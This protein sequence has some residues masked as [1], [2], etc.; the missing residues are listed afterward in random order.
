M[1]IS[2]LLRRVKKKRKG[3][4]LSRLVILRNV[5]GIVFVAKGLPTFL[6]MTKAYVFKEV[7]FFYGGRGCAVPCRV[8]VLSPTSSERRHGEL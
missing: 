7:F 2:L 3:F 8:A 1:L 4:Y 5:G 6:K